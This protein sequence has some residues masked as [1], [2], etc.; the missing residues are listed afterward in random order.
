MKNFKAFTLTELM[1]VVILIGIIAAFALP[2][3]Q[4]AILKAHERDAVVQLTVIHAALKIYEAQ[5]NTYPEGHFDLTNINTTL[6]LNVIGNGMR[7]TYTSL[8]LGK[9]FQVDAEWHDTAGS[10]NNFTIRVNEEAIDPGTN[11]NPCCES[12]KDTCPSLPAC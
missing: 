6:G 10:A 7:Y 8:S 3:Y 11:P 5:A 4:K 12:G 9:Q 2:N 1:V